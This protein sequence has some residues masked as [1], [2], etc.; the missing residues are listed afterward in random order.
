MRME[1]PEGANMM[2]G[3]GVARDR[4][5]ARTRRGKEPSC[6]FLAGW[7]FLSQRGYASGT[8]V[9]GMVPGS[10]VGRYGRFRC[11]LILAFTI[12]PERKVGRKQ[13]GPHTHYSRPWRQRVHSHNKKQQTRLAGQGNQRGPRASYG[14]THP[15]GALLTSCFIASHLGR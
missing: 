13:H 6:S 8:T 1:F 12:R 5:A 9:A 4:S 10:S 11:H 2:A 15:G 14:K 7:H 3:R